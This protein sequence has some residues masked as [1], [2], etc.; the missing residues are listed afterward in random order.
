MGKTYTQKIN[1]F[2]GGISNDIRSKDLRYF[3]FA[4]HLDSFSYPHK[5][6]PRFGADTKEGGNDFT[7]LTTKPFRFLYAPRGNNGNYLFA[8][9]KYTANAQPIVIYFDNDTSEWVAPTNG[10][11]GSG[12]TVVNDAFFEYKGYAYMWD[13]SAGKLM[14][15]KLDASEAFNAAYQ[16]ITGGATVF[17]CAQPVHFSIDDV[18]YFFSDN[19]VHSLNDTVWTEK[20]LTLPSDS[21]IVGAAEYGQYLV[22]AVNYTTGTKTSIFF[23]DRD[24]SLATITSRYDI[25]NEETYKIGV[26]SGRIML[27]TSGAYKINVRRYNGAEFEKIKEISSGD[28]RISLSVSD[29]QQEAIVFEDKM[30]FPMT[31]TPPDASSRLA[32][33][34]LDVS[35]R[36]V[37]DTTVNGATSYQGIFF[38]SGLLWIAHSDLHVVRTNRTFS[39]T[40]TTIYESL[41][42]GDVSENKKLIK[43]G[44][45]TEPL[46][47][48]GQIVLKYRLTETGSWTTI[49]THTTDGSYYHDAIN[50]ESTGVTLPEYREIQFRIESIGGA[51]ILG[52]DLKYEIK[53]DNLA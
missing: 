26:I 1:S 50:I 4:S 32:I 44:V 42:L 43:V 27:V 29:T 35:G 6:V 16:T 9:A 19:F 30:F 31:Y 47:T 22:I 11:G 17:R 36:L 37:A 20:V 45:S 40:P 48:A 51:V 53:E 15:Y 3:A 7:S 38:L 2:N 46:P 13:G 49:F 5:L 8:L 34:A 41:M 10:A 28:E 23:W 39:T 33:W 24:S 52:L 18:A 14:R 21:Y 25:E 12:T